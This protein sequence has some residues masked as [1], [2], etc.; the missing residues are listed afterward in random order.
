MHKSQVIGVQVCERKLDTKN[1][2]RHIVGVTRRGRKGHIRLYSPS[3]ALYTLVRQVV[4]GHAA[5]AWFDDDCTTYAGFYPASG[6]SPTE[7]DD[8]HPYTSYQW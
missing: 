4:S 1:G 3:D 6:D 8:S 2:R 5:R 7:P